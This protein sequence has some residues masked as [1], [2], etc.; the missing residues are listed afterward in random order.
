MDSFVQKGYK[1]IGNAMFNMNRVTTYGIFAVWKPG[2]MTSSD[3]ACSIRRALIGGNGYLPLDERIMRRYGSDFSYKKN[4]MWIKVG[5]GGTIDRSAEGVLVIG[6][7]RSCSELGQYLNKKD[8]EYEFTAKLGVTTTTLDASGEVSEE[9]PWEHVTR[10]CLEEILHEFRGTIDQVP[11]VYSAKKINGR[12]SSDIAIKASKDES[13]SMPVLSPT[14]IT[15]NSIRLSSFDPPFY[16]ITV[17]CSSGTYVRSLARDIGRRLGTCSYC[18]HLQR[19]S[20]GGFTRK[21]ALVEEDWTY[22][23]IKQELQ[24]YQA[25]RSNRTFLSRIYDE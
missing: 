8:K 16:S 21:I 20:Q 12:R 22:D 9:A 17:S 23:N 4:R 1:C 3:A 15:I 11:P 5:H 19:V 18:T 10:E 14:K 6:V 24:K 2:N 25:F 13:I 7:G